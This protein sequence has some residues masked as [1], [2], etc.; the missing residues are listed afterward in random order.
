MRKMLVVILWGLSTALGFAQSEEIV[1]TID[2]PDKEVEHTEP[3]PE[4]PSAYSPDEPQEP[5]EEPE[6]PHNIFTRYFQWGKQY[7]IRNGFYSLE[8]LYIAWDDDRQGVGLEAF[9]FRYSFL[10]FTSVGASVLLYSIFGEQ[11]GTFTAGMTI[12]AGLVAPITSILQFFCDG[13]LE[14]GRNDWGGLIVGV[15]WFALNPGYALGL[16]LDF[17]NIGFEL[18]YKGTWHPENRYVNF[19]GFGCTWS[20]WNIWNLWS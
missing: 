11:G 20:L 6:S 7:G 1:E 9:D 8:M 17:G 10:P 12:H 3:E 5:Q 13:I 15:G 4:P 18:K 19:L 16:S 14:I 2:V